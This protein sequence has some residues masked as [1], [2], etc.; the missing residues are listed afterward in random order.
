M[1]TEAQNFI[2]FKN[3]YSLLEGKHTAMGMA[4]VSYILDSLSFRELRCRLFRRCSVV[5]T[6]DCTAVAAGEHSTGV[7]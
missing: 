4:I 5:R 7:V 1:P 2:S 3:C 6:G